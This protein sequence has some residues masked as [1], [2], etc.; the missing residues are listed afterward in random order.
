MVRGEALWREAH[1]RHQCDPEHPLAEVKLG[2]SHAA[3]V[4][5]VH[6]AAGSVKQLNLCSPFYL[7]DPGT[8]AP[9]TAQFCWLG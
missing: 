6:K 3:A 9:R 8:S 4:R 5:E 1:I 7:G 2:C